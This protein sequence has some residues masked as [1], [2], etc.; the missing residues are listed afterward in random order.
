ME[1]EELLYYFLDCTIDDVSFFILF[2]NISFLII[3][4]IIDIIYAAVVRFCIVW[5]FYVGLVV[6]RSFDI[7]SF[8]WEWRRAQAGAVQ[9]EGCDLLRRRMSR[10]RLH[11]LLLLRRACC[12]RKKKVCIR[13][14]S[15][16]VTTFRGPCA[17]LPSRAGTF[18]WISYRAQ[19]GSRTTLASQR[20]QMR[21]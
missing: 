10:R 3:I 19:M 1:R 5:T 11:C 18:L 12:R 15:S 16:Q 17:R 8:W 20:C 13:G 9:R 21:M 2:I 7:L 6:A 4:K 14:K